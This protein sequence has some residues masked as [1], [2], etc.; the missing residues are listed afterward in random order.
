MRYFMFNIDGRIPNTNARTYGRLLME[1]EIFPSE[2]MVED[3]VRDK[4][5]LKDVTITGIFEFKSKED[6]DLYVGDEA[7]KPLSDIE[8]QLMELRQISQINGNKVL[9]GIINDIS[10]VSKLNN[11][12]LETRNTIHNTVRDALKCSILIGNEDIPTIDTKCRM[13]NPIIETCDHGHKYYKEAGIS[14]RCPYCLAI[15]LDLSRTELEN[16]KCDYL[17]L[18]TEHTSSLNRHIDLQNKHKSLQDRYII[19]FDKYYNVSDLEGD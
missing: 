10:F 11:L 17:K 3:V 7:V 14:P 2:K 18:Q 1:H 6:Y 8:L 4:N 9:E 13:G 19:L 15:G 12:M 5:P 16:T